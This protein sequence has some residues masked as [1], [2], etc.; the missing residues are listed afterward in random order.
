MTYSVASL[1]VAGNFCDD[2]D[3]LYC[4]VRYGSH[5][6]HVVLEHLKCGWCNGGSEV[7][8]LWNLKFT[9][10]WSHVS[11]VATELGGTVIRTLCIFISMAR[12]LP[13]WIPSH[14]GGSRLRICLLK[15]LQLV[16]AIAWGF[17]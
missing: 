1:Y 3:R 6:P 15:I 17:K 11:H 12:N 14:R 16:K 13:V 7:L 10:T 2:G 9:F 8:I 5:Q 4:P